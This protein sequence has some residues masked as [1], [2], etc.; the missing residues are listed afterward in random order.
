MKKGLSLIL[1]LVL[2]V[3]SFAVA[4]ADNSLQNEFDPEK[5]DYYYYATVLNELGVFHGTDN[6]FELERA[7][8]RAEALVMFLR[9]LGVDRQA[10]EENIQP[11]FDDVPGWAKAYV[12]YA[13]A[14]GLASGVGGGKFG[15][16]NTVSAKDYATFL[17]RGL[18]YSDAAGDFSW[19]NSIDFLGANSEISNEYIKYIKT[20]DFIRGDM[21]LMSHEALISHTKGGEV[22]V[23]KLGLGTAIK[24][25]Y[26]TLA[27]DRRPFSIRLELLNMGTAKLT[28]ELRYYSESLDFEKDG[29]LSPVDFTYDR[30]LNLLNAPKEV[31][32]NTSVF[33]NE[34]L[35]KYTLK[36][37][38]LGEPHQTFLVFVFDESENKVIKN[39]F[40]VRKPIVEIGVSFTETCIYFVPTIAPEN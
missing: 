28:E 26:T 27:D 2:V 7:A 3:S 14:N 4:F 30:L 10:E 39:A 23:E 36:S 11:S 32:D 9:I 1:C 33:S 29:V 40:I 19:N 21:A 24:I 38:E 34:Y 22:L 31:F 37:D 13:E 12:G 8:T 17:L 6:G 18:G 15:S 35:E 20:A 5:P 25:K 16:N